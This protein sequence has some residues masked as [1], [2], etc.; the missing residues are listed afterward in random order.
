MSKHYYHGGADGEL[1][2]YLAEAS[3]LIDQEVED[4]VQE[5]VDV[6]E[7]NGYVVDALLLSDK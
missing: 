3:D 2:Q 6:A 4:D 1:L 7:K 5:I